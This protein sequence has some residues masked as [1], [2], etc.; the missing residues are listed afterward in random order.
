MISAICSSPTR[1]EKASSAGGGI[2]PSLSFATQS[3]FTQALN[4][5]GGRHWTFGSFK[6]LV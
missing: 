2:M 3:T 5:S 1:R 6:M 4:S